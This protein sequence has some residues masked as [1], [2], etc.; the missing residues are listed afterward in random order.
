LIGQAVDTSIFIMIAFYGIYSG[1]LIWTIFISNYIFK[2]AFEIIFTPGTYSIVGF[3]KK[4]EGLE[5]FDRQ[6]NFNPFAL[7]AKETC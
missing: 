7:R 5:V 1:G 4:K 3:L 6:T 2:V